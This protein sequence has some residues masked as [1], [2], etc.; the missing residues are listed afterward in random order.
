MSES[1]LDD[2]R[3]T[4]AGRYIDGRVKSLILDLAAPRAGGATPRRGLRQRRESGALPPQGLRRDRRRPISVPARP[5]RGEAEEPS[6]AAH[7][8]ARGAPL[9]RQRVRRRHPAQLPRIRGRSRQG[10]SRGDPGLPGQ[11]PGRGDEPLVRTG[12]TGEADRPFRSPATEQGPLLPPGVPVGHG[13]Q[14][15]PGGP[16]LL[17]ERHLPPLGVVRLRH[18]PRGAPARD[19]KPLRRLLLPGLFGHVLVPHHPGG[20]PRSRTGDPGG[21]EDRCR[22]WPPA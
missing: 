10:R 12:G 22:A 18:G 14:A 13:P 19:G 20:D 8:R 11:G 6:R 16:H 21:G 7:R 17:G 1:I 3:T 5:G 2:W 4:A 9:L 15:A